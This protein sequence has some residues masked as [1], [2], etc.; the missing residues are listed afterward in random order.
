VNPVR[1]N[2]TEGLFCRLLPRI[3]RHTRPQSH[4]AGA[5]AF[6]PVSQLNSQPQII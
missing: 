4:N 6:A 2:D 5:F 1:V 3:R